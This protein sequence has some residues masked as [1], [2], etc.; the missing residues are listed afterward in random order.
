MQILSSAIRHICCVSV[1]ALA[2]IGVEGGGVQANGGLQSGL[3]QEAAYISA[4]VGQPEEVLD[5][6]MILDR[7]EPGAT[8]SLKQGTYRGPAV[9]RKPLRLVAQDEGDVRLLNPSEESA[10]TIEADD[11]TVS[12]ITVMDESLKASATILVA[13]D[14]VSL[15]ELRIVTGSD[16]IAAKDANDGAVLHT[17]I[18]WSPEGIAMAK[19]G[20]GIDLF[21]SHRWHVEGNDIRNVH[22]GIYMESSNDTIVVGNMI[23]ESRYGI[24]CM[25]TN[26]TI[27]RDNEGLANI[28]G[29]MVM[30][31]RDVVLTNNVFTKQSENVHS[32]GILLFDAHDSLF[33]NN[34]IEGNRAGLY[35][36]QST[37]NQFLGNRVAY[38]FVGLQLLEAENNVIEGNLFQGNVADAQAKGSQ[39]NEISGNYW[40][41]FQGIDANGDGYSDVSY[42]I[43]PFFQGLTQKRAAFQLFFQSPGMVFLE[44]LYQTGREQW[45]ADRRPLMEPPAIGGE[46]AQQENVKASGI[47]G[48]AL[49]GATIMLVYMNRRR[50]I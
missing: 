21:Q 6:Q 17:E 10:L 12:G 22:D 42:S 34:T 49:L 5:L 20:N 31:T 8:V 2:L 1:A 33:E 26:G 46:Q 15:E 32:Q 40:D 19:K 41:S 44:G 38:N 25:Y 36:E 35:I 39:R 23:Q 13:G 29:A 37:G 47:A 45:S 28:T 24:H 11:V 3:V 18:V 27:I 50:T 14:R 30:T 9:I 48:L 16:G 4:E 43:N 7:A